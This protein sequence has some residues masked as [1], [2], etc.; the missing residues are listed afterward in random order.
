MRALPAVAAL[1]VLVAAAAGWAQ[2]SANDRKAIEACLERD[3]DT[4]GDKCIGIVAD[5]CIASVHG[6]SEKAKACAARELALWE[7]EMEA[8]LKRVR[9][10][11][12]TELSRASDQAQQSWKASLDVLCSAFDKVDPGMLPGGATTC[13]MHETASR[14]LMLRRL[15]EAVSEH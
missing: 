8:A 4:L 13:R 12:F 5:P 6:E 7:A 14:A 1:C 2:P 15:G 9:A 3:R 10:G 11:G